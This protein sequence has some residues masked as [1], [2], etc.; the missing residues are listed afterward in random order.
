LLHTKGLDK[1]WC[2]AM[3]EYVHEGV[4]GF[5]MCHTHKSEQLI[6]QSK[7]MISQVSISYVHVPV[8]EGE[9]QFEGSNEGILGRID[10][11]YKFI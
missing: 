1:C 3:K 6:L 7:F 5:E 2:E 4:Y 10:N 8:L 11:I 9:L